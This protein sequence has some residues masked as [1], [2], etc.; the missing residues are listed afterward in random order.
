MN[1]TD[2][3]QVAENTD[4]LREKAVELLAQ[5]KQLHLTYSS[6]CLAAAIAL[7]EDAEKDCAILLE[8]SRIKEERR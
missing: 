3:R 2:V 6:E 5:F 4:W 8:M 7:I 1:L